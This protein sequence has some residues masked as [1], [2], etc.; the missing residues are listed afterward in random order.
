MLKVSDMRFIY[1]LN[2]TSNF[3]NVSQ[4]FSFRVNHEATF[5]TVLSGSFEDNLLQ[6]NANISVSTKMNYDVLNIVKDLIAREICISVYS[7]N[8]FPN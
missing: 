5:I 3:S 4:P 1:W 7:I 8:V 6:N 2:K